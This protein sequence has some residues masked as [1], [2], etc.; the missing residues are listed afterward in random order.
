MFLASHNSVR[1]AKK[2][3]RPC[4][5]QLYVD[6]VVRAV[7]DAREASDYNLLAHYYSADVLCVRYVHACVLRMSTEMALYCQTSE[8]NS[9]PDALSRG[10][11]VLSRR[12][13]ALRPATVALLLSF[14][15]A[16]ATR[17]RLAMA[18]RVRLDDDGSTL[19]IVCVSTTLWTTP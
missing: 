2:C 6:R 15:L 1:S 5:V 10:P 17:V 18:S 11:V 12:V 8:E 14:C 3:S 19:F 9:V 7:V 13:A 16:M 4:L